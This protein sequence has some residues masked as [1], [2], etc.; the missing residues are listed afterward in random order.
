M[1]VIVQIHLSNEISAH[2]A[3]GRTVRMR[4]VPNGNVIRLGMT[5]RPALHLNLEAKG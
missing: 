4:G 2:R 5:R 3:L 1:S